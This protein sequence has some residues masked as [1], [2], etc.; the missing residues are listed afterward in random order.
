MSTGTADFTA[1]ATHAELEA[2]AV[3]LR[4]RNFEVLVV[5]NSAEAA[6]AV[7]ER[8]PDG[9]LVHA[10]KS[11]TLEDIGV[12]QQLMESDR[13]D[14]VR[15]RTQAMDRRTQRDEMRRLGAAPDVMLGSVQ[16]VTEAG[17]LVIVSASG[18]QIGPYGSGAGKLIVVV[19]AQK[20]VQDMERAYE[21]IKQHVFPYEDARLREQ[22]GVGTRWTR[23]LILESDFGPG[24][25]T[26]ILVEEPVGV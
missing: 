22:L 5:A 2:L 6:A 23:T 7:M 9:A 14:F 4:E 21:R 19:G 12:F 10:G 24:R 17:Q 1:P 11:K 25:T 20:I 16:A 3:K 18:S 13:F 8:I 15:R 26:V